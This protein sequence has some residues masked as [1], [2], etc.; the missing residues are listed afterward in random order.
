MT[1]AEYIQWARDNCETP[2]APD[3]ASFDEAREAY[4]EV[5]HRLGDEAEGDD[6]LTRT[7]WM[8]I[9]I[10]LAQLGWTV[11][12][13]E[14]TRWPVPNTKVAVAQLLNEIK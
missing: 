10:R 8:E 1:T 11:E 2:V 12:E 4:D 7:L 3:Q 13:F 9:T 6:F 5:D 14:D